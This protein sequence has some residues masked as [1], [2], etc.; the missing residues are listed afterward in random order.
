[1]RHR[2][3]SIA[4][5]LGVSALSLA[6]ADA[7]FEL[8]QRDRTVEIAASGYRIEVAREGFALRVA[9]GAET[10]V[11]SAQAGDAGANLAFD[12]G[13]AHHRVTKLRS[14]VRE[15]EAV[16][17]LYD[18]TLA[19]AQARV[20]LEPGADR[21]RISEWILYGVGDIALT[22]R[23][24]MAPSAD[25]YGGGFQNPMVLPLNKAELNKESFFINA[26]TQAS[27]FWYTTKGVGLW[28]RTPHDFRYA[29][30][31]GE[32]AVEMPGVSAL[33][34]DIILAKDIRAVVDRINREIGH[35][36]TA[37]PADYLRLPSYSTWAEHKLEVSQAKIHDYVQA[38][39]ANK[40]ACGAFIIDDKWES[41]YGDLRLDPPRFPDPKAMVAELH[42]A[43]CKVMLW[44][45]PFANLESETYRDQRNHKYFIHDLAGRPA[46]VTWWRGSGA[47][48]DFTNGEA[49]AAFLARLE[50]LQKEL[51]LDGFKF[52]SGDVNRV[53][54]DGRTARPATPAEFADIYNR[55]MAARFPWSETRVGVYSG[56]LGV[57][58]RLYDK[59]SDWTAGN[60]L[61]AI[62]PEA[63]LHSLRGFPYVMADM[64]GGNEYE[65]LK[66][67]KEL[68]VRWAQATALLPLM[69][70]SKA[71]WSFGADAAKL[72][73]EATELHMAFAPY[74]YRLAMET[75]RT[76]API[77]RPLW[78][79]APGDAEA[80]R[81]M[82][83]FMLGDDVVVAPVMT[84]GALARD[85][86]L[87]AGNWT[88]YKTGQPQAGGLWLRAYPAPLDRVPV[89]VRAG[90][91]IH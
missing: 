72:C 13:G 71:P 74:T 22:L 2:V 53:P 55:E 50:K 17:L 63:F 21:I 31:N 86:Y 66:I 57:V 73:R 84:K 43:G 68:I 3:V 6:A 37:P 46:M 48:W 24:R 39:R 33:D 28:I 20:R 59:E 81:I 26:A 79:N 30:H 62:I 77:V 47:I 61:G 91:V 54:P 69:Q 70:F 29:I 18:T 1:M 41:E 65:N 12:F 87:P 10:V 23:Y 9:R 52:D 82:D 40:Y 11:E 34:Y 32:L 16:I 4:V 27:P 25:W 67:D 76:G 45:H 49:V 36:H 44:I 8:E 15:G 42:G 58:E 60:G 35:P 89:F 56:P 14:A 38:M 85:V 75:V 78:Y 5:V 83:Q 7:G 80:A 51:G 88:D 64:V 19:G 90:V